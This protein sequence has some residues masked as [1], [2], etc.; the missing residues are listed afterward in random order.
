MCLSVHL[1]HLCIYSSIATT[2]PSSYHLYHPPFSSLWQLSSIL[3]CSIMLFL[4]SIVV[5]LLCSVKCL[6]HS[7]VTESHTKIHTYT[8]THS[9]SHMIRLHHSPDHHQAAL[10][11]GRKLRIQQKTRWAW[12]SDISD[13]NQV[14]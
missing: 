7:K 12:G 14:S 9:F 11:P 8:H 1:P 10:G 6:L 4:V 5:G 2:F 13:L 3:F